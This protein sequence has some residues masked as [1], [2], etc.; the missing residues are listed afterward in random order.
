MPGQILRGNLKLGDDAATA[1]DVSL[2]VT[3]FELLLQATAVLVPQT[4][5]SVAQETRKGPET[6]TLTLTYFNEDGVDTVSA[7]LVAAFEAG[8][9]LYFEGTLQPGAPSATNEVWFGTIAQTTTMKGGTAGA[10]GQA[11]STLPVNSWGH[12]ITAVP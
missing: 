3:Q 12:S 7:L 11:T 6:N 8:T 2:L 9:D 10:L 4:F 5:G 1:V